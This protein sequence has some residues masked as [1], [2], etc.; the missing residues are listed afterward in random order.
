VF[1]RIDLTKGFNALSTQEAPSLAPI[2]Q[3]SWTNYWN[4]HYS[5]YGISAMSDTNIYKNLNV[6]VGARYDY[7]SAWG[8]NGDG[9][10]PIKVRGF[11]PLGEHEASNNDHGT[12]WTASLSYKL[13]NFT[14]YVTKAS[15]STIISG[16]AGDLDTQNVAN[17]TFL[18]DS[19]LTEY[20]IKTSQ[21]NGRLFA[22]IARYEQSRIAF[23]AQSPVSNQAAQ[24]KGTE[25]EL[26]VV[27]I[28]RLSLVATY[29]NMKVRMLIPSGVSFTDVGSTDLKALTDPSA[30]FSGIIGGNVAVGTA[31]NRG[32][33][34]QVTWALSGSFKVTQSLTA[35]MSLTSVDKTPSGILGTLILPAYKLVNASMIYNTKSFKLGFFVDNLTNERYFR[36]NFPSVYGSNSVL[37]ELPRNWRAEVTYRF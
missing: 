11:D 21:F 22:A 6:L 32:G 5:Q 23:D 17:K 10:G 19:K 13:G 8:Q 37:P 1:D 31:P 36:G 27:P 34:P 29:S 24:T 16:S 20:G 28:D 12:T 18:G 7:V 30:A 3:E 4:S 25:V 14:P 2:G 15:E 26:R 35:N 9:A 33:I